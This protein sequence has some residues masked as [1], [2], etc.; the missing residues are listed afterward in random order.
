M[1]FREQSILRLTLEVDDDVAAHDEMDVFERRSR[2]EE[3][4]ALKLDQPPNLRPHC[5][6]TACLGEILPAQ[7]GG[8]VAKGCFAV[9]RGLRLAQALNIDVGSNDGHAIETRELAPL[10]SMLV[11]EDRQGVSLFSRRASGAPDS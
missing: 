9:R 3:I 2:A 4:P 5:E 8:G 10:S 7:C 1:K 11:G 6:N